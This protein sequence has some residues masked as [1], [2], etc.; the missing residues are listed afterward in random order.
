MLDTAYT[1]IA[2]RV[3]VLRT[4]VMQFFSFLAASVTVPISVDMSNI[5]RGSAAW[6]IPFTINVSTSIFDVHVDMEI[7][8][9]I[10][11]DHLHSSIGWDDIQKLSCGWFLC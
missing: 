5:V 4:L 10:E 8:L 9:G 7:F 2:H 6:M 3:C 11:P 1:I